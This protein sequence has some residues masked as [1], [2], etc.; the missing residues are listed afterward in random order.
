MKA[1]LLSGGLGTRLLPATKHQNKHLL[2]IYANDGAHPIIC[3][4]INTLSKSGLT[5]IL[6]ISSREHCGRIMETL[7]DG[8]DF[9]VNF[10]YKIQDT[11]HVHLG[12]AS[13]LKLAKDFTKDEKFAVILGDNFF[14]DTF[15]KEMCD[16]NKSDAKACLFL[17]KV[18]D[19]QRFGCA[20]INNG[21]VTKIVE[22]PD[23][24]ESNWA[25][26]G[27]YLYTPEVYEIADQLVP[28][29]R[30][31]LEISDINDYYC[32]EIINACF[33][34]GYWSDMGTPQS[35]VNTQEYIKSINFC[36]TK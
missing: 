16:F 24:P 8:Y 15:K 19:I 9:G 35:L 33:L 2:P 4:P 26:T 17:K 22:K 14:E 20:T 5:D 6:V 31:E 29:L 30:G 18:A 23:T 7:S 34:T 1:I 36:L 3:Y 27:L 25:V 13:A 12:I 28:S 32:K 10:T 21:K 11:S